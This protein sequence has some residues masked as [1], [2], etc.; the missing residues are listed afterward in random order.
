MQSRQRRIRASSE[1]QWA[2]SSREPG[3][4]VG[5]CSAV[6]F[7]VAKSMDGGRKKME[8]MSA[9]VHNSDRG[10]FNHVEGQSESGAE[11]RCFRTDG[12]QTGRRCPGRYP[13]PCLLSV[14]RSRARHVRRC[15]RTPTNSHSPTGENVNILRT[16]R[17]AHG[18]CEVHGLI[19]TARQSSRPLG[20][21]FICHTGSPG[22]LRRLPQT[23]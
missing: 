13:A 22:S 6:R 17:P 21:A 16:R 20:S 2:C 9:S 19:R 4:D 5:S 8:R 11:A 7:R 23:R 18:S 12:W 1:G 15:F 10:H 14:S 3:L